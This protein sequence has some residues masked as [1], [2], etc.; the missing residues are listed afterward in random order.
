MLHTAA[1]AEHFWSFS[2]VPVRLEDA[3]TSCK[4]VLFNPQSWCTHGTW[5]KRANTRPSVMPQ[6]QIVL[7]KVSLGLPLTYHWRACFCFPE[8]CAA[9]QDVCTMP[10]ATNQFFYTRFAIGCLPDWC[11]NGV[12]M[13]TLCVSCQ[14]SGSIVCLKIN[15]ATRL[16]C[17]SVLAGAGCLPRRALRWRHRAPPIQHCLPAL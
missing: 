13:Q 6:H 17:Q 10:C 9:F 12:P 15:S 2:I 14:I 8:W 7:S 3:S 4:L 16:V 5:H 1:A 11:A